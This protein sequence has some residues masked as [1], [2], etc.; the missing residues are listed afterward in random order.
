MKLLAIAAIVLGIWV[1][2][3]T[4]PEAVEGQEQRIGYIPN[5]PNGHRI[6]VSCTCA[7][8]A[9]KYTWV[10]EFERN[11]RPMEAVL[12]DYG[13][14]PWACQLFWDGEGEIIYDTY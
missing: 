8:D 3:F 12:S 13:R 2:D 4:V 5:D 9:T 7:G 6:W 1:S 10:A 14:G 11:A